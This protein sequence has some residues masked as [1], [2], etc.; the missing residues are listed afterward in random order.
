MVEE[1]RRP[2]GKEYLPTFAVVT[3]DIMSA[4]RVAVDYINV[5]GAGGSSRPGPAG[6]AC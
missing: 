1:D 2:K 4:R 5:L 3:H 6:G